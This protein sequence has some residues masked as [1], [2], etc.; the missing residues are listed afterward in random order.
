MPTSQ[1]PLPPSGANRVMSTPRDAAPPTIL[2]SALGRGVV[3][4]RPRNLWATRP[5]GVPRCRLGSRVRRRRRPSRTRLQ[6]RRLPFSSA[7]LNLTSAHDPP[8]RSVRSCRHPRR[9]CSPRSC[10]PR[11]HNPRDTRRQRSAPASASA[12]R[13]GDWCPTGAEAPAGENR[14]I[15]ASASASHNFTISSPPSD[16][17]GRAPTRRR[18][19]T[20]PDR[21]GMAAAGKTTVGPRQIVVARAA[22]RAEVEVRSQRV[23]RVHDDER[24]RSRRSES[25]ARTGSAR[26]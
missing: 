21:S 24:C 14:C 25:G 2:L 19:R 4:P 20:R 6:K 5:L 3:A 26:G 1:Y 7:L 17:A 13:A 16:R 23:E 12:I 11:A 10:H 22:G 15:T 18:A 9:G 8:R